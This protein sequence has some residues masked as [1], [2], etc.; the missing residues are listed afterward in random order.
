MRGAYKRRAEA[1][2]PQRVYET[3]SFV[4]CHLLTQSVHRPLLD[5]RPDPRALQ[6]GASLGDHQAERAA[7]R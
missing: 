5:P 6:T 2:G 7:V 3:Y 1:N 4:R